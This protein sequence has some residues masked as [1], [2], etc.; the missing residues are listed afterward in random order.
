MAVVNP[1]DKF[2]MFSEYWS[3]RIV[4]ELNESY[5]KAVKL[6]GEFLWHTH[7]SEDEM[8][9]VVKG[10]LV[11][12]YRDVDNIISPGEFLIIPRGTE[13]MPVAE[14]EVH[15]LLIEPKS[16]VNTGDVVCERTADAE[17]AE[18]I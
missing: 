17:A 14:E 1:E 16:T 9:F 15:A 18:R 7:E 12:R 3:P 2:A 10:R 8:F 5:I 11:I 13:H 6:K 4:G